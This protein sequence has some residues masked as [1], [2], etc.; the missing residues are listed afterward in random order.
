MNI[1]E[2]PKREAQK[3]NIDDLT[4]LTYVVSKCKARW[5]HLIKA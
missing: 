4:L 5:E 3:I 2:Y 1:Y